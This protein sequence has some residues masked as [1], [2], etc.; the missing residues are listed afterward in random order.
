MSVTQFE[1]SLIE[2]DI[3]QIKYNFSEDYYWFAI[4]FTNSTIFKFDGNLIPTDELATEPR[5]VLD[6]KCKISP[7]S[8]CV[9]MRI[10]DGSFISLDGWK[11]NSKVHFTTNK[12][13]KK[14]WYSINSKRRSKK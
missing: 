12:I 4:L 7:T 2:A 10:S 11:E 8:F 3:D 1:T 6:M 5:K 9:M 13:S 14:D